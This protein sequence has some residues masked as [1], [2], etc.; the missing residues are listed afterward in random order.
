MTPLTLVLLRHAKAETPGATRDV[1]RQLTARGR[2][3]AQAAGAWLDA[4]GLRP[5][6]VL[7]SPAIRT[8]QTWHAVAV[9][10]AQA[11]PAGGAPEVRYERALYEGGRTELVDLLRA[12][13]QAVT[14]VLIVGHNPTMS[15]ASVLLAPEPTMA[16][17]RT[18]GL[19]VHRSSGAWADTEPGS[20][21][22]VQRHTARP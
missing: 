19:A 6:L 14:N 8:R 4:Q 18:C 21:E 2:D 17:L 12:V 7:C 1:D 9:A 10:L 5:E 15:D 11:N 3:D 22:L 16:E 20:A 13:P